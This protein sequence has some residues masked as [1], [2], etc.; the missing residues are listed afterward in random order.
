MQPV[1]SQKI[2]GLEGPTFDLMFCYQHLEILHNFIFEV[3]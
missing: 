2:P 1:E 3:Q